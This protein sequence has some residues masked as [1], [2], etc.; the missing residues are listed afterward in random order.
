MSAAAAKQ[1]LGRVVALDQVTVQYLRQGRLVT[2]LDNVSLAIGPRQSIGILGTKGS[3]KTTLLR[4][5][6]GLEI[7]SSGRLVHHGMTVSWPLWARTGL[8]RTMTVRDN[9]RFL[10]QLYG[11]SPPDLIRSVDDFAQLGGAMDR[12]LGDL[13]S[14]A[15]AKVMCAAAIGLGF[16]CYPVD[17][18]LVSSDKAFRARAD[19]ILRSL[20]ERSSLVIGSSRTAYIR[21]NCDVAYVLHQ[22][23]LTRH[24]RTDDAIRFYRECAASLEATQD[25][26]SA[27]EAGD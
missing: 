17:G 6:A 21:D 20:R 25:P 4:L 14:T 5:L 26:E 11:R 22:G 12:L 24:D 23:V 7:P 15:A 18:M 13:P 19:G 1:G 16:D 10:A 27:E 3:G 9:I 8:M 2:A